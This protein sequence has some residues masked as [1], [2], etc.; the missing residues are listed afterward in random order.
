MFESGVVRI[1]WRGIISPCTA[2]KSACVT[3]LISK[4]VEKSRWGPE[5]HRSGWKLLA[6]VGVYI[7]FARLGGGRGSD[8]FLSCSCCTLWMRKVIVGC[9]GL[10]LS[11]NCRTCDWTVVMGSLGIGRFVSSEIRDCLGIRLG[12]R[13]KFQ[14]AGFWLG[15]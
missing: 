7:R 15:P 9:S 3:V 11:N 1:P 8:G 4:D 13:V 5:G 6:E 12:K 10:G 2:V 14:P